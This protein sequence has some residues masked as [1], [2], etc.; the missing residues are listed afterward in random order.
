MV[1]FKILGSL[2]NA[3]SNYK[4]ISPL[5]GYFFY[6]FNNAVTNANNPTFT[7]WET[8]QKYYKGQ[9]WHYGKV[10]SKIMIY[11]IYFTWF[12]NQILIQIILLNFLISVISNSYQAIIDSEIIITYTF[13]AGLNREYLIIQKALTLDSKV[14]NLIL[15]ANTEDESLNSQWYKFTS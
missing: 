8:L 5:F 15:S 14:G 11:F 1:L 3:A 10:L 13:K 7:I 6:N 12:I 4:N 9:P 2:N